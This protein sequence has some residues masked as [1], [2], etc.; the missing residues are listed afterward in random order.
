[1]L[2][3]ARLIM[4]IE[5]FG[6]GKQLVRYRIWPHFSRGGLFFS[7]AWLFFSMLA[8][9]NSALIPGWVVGL[10]GTMTAVRMLFESATQVALM[11]NKVMVPITL[12]AGSRTAMEKTDPDSV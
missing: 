12:H 7:L 8:F 3:S 10:L 1:M 11:R 6:G 4:G 9:M 5:E 2:G